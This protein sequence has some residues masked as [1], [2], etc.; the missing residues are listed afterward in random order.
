MISGPARA[1]VTRPRLR[2]G[3]AGLATPWH[4]G[5]TVPGAGTRPRIVPYNFK[6]KLNRA[7]AGGPG[8][9]PW[10]RSRSR[11]AP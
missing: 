3:P 4:H 2:V 10:I 9:S 11:R 7:R 6:S 1:A 8:G 5:V